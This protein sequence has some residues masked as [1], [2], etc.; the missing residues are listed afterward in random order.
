MNPLAM[1]ASEK[2]RM[3]TKM[4]RVCSLRRELAIVRADGEAWRELAE[5]HYRDHRCGAIDKIFAVRR[6]NNGDRNTAWVSKLPILQ[7]NWIHGLS[8]RGRLGFGQ[9]AVGVIVYAMPVPNV[10]L[11]NRATANR[12]VG[13]GSKAGALGLLNAEMRCISRVVI[14]PSWR[15]MGLARWLV[16]ETLPQAG[17]VL[18][19][20]LAAMGRVHPFFEQAGMTRYEG[21][22]SADSV[23]LIEA[24]RTVGITDTALSDTGRLAAAWGELGGTERDWVGREVAR[25]GARFGRPGRR[26][27]D[28]LRSGGEDA[29]GEIW[30]EAAVLVVKH[31]WS[32]PVYYLWRR[33]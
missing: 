12:Y 23:R 14:H 3:A 10:A 28:G 31:V 25:F 11:R 20:A 6:K 7:E 32:N 30:H 15:G 21:E 33:L 4:E 13:L 8:G 18:V 9:R 26:I 24:M 5:Y 22:L 2:V 17:T 1:G 29:P 27:A 19:E 16:A